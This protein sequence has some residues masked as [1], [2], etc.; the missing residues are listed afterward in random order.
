MGSKRSQDLALVISG[1]QK[2]MNAAV[3][4]E[5]STLEKAWQN[6]SVKNT[7]KNANNIDFPSVDPNLL[8]R[9]SALIIE[10]SAIMSQALALTSLNQ[11]IKN[12]GYVQS[13]QKGREKFQN[14]EIHL[15]EEELEEFE[16]LEKEDHLP[17]LELNPS[18]TSLVSSYCN[19]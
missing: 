3:K 13:I 4:Q 6:P 14:E 15:Y 2:V 12:L 19:Y 9:R 17:I 18:V 10:N 7:F 11:T 1:L 5:F 16:D 8:A